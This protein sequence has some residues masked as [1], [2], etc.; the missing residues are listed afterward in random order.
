MFVVQLESNDSST[1]TSGLT[2]DLRS[3]V[4]PFE[5]ITP[6]LLSRMKQWNRLACISINGLRLNA[7]VPVAEGTS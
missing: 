1:T 6:A 2:D 4:A 5:V 7:F 3:V